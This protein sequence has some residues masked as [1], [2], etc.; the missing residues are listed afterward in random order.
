ME[1]QELSDVAGSVLRHVEVQVTSRVSGADNDDNA[2]FQGR[3]GVTVCS[4]SPEP[5]QGLEP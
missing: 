5:V 1:D 2:L 4:F 3:K